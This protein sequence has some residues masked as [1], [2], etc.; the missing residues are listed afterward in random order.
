[1]PPQLTLA[2]DINNQN[3]ESNHIYLS[4]FQ[5]NF[6]VFITVQNGT[7]QITCAVENLLNTSPTND[8]VT[9]TAY[10]NNS[11]METTMDIS[12]TYNP[13][14]MMKLLENTFHPRTLSESEKAVSSPVRCIKSGQ[15]DPLPIG[16]RDCSNKLMTNI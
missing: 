14:T 12:N 16:V 6:F 3:I 5:T 8:V 9:T 15:R 13:P 11:T 10:I 1:M 2:N 7:N 4:D